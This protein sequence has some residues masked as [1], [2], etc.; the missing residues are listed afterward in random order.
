MT[1]FLMRLAA[2]R[3]ALARTPI[4]NVFGLSFL[5]LI[6]WGVLSLTRRGV[7]FL[8]EFPAIGSIS[9][10]VMRRSLEGLFLMLML[11]VAFSVLT[12]A[13]NT[14]YSSE[15]L[16]LLLSLPVEPYRVF[17]LKVAETYVTSAM[18]PALFTAPVLIGIGLE[19]GAGVG[20]YLL[21]LAAVLAL[22]A[23]PVALGAFIALVL[24]RISPSGRVKE[25]ASA[26]SVLVAAGLI[27][28]LRALRPEQLTAMNIAEFE[29][30]LQR[31]AAFEIGWMPPAW[32]SSAVLGAL[33]GR[34][35]PAAYLLAFV[36]LLLL[37]AV[38]YLAA[39]A[40]REGWV[41]SLDTGRPRL[42]PV[43]RP[44]SLWERP[45]L[46]LGRSGGIIVK[47]TRLL[48][49]DPTQWS[50]LL[51]LLALAGVYLVSTSSID[52]DLQRFKD[53]VGTMNLVFL[54]FLLAGVGIRTV[55]PVVSMEAQG[56]W[57]L[58]T[59]PIRSGQIV[60]AK[61]LHALPVM[62]VLGGGLGLLAARLLDLSPTLAYAAPIAGLLSALAVTGLGVGLGAAFPRF[63]AVSASEIPLSAGGLLYMTS[64]LAYAAAQTVLLAYPAWR[65]IRDPGQ[66]VWLEAEGVLLLG[67]ALV[68]TLAA[69]ALPLW[70]GSRR[71]ARFEPGEA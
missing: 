9:D 54:G 46:R 14:L 41:R 64:A 4:R 23:I 58:K 37:A 16:P 18:L 6:Y 25:V 66:L 50:Q 28:G 60:L 15:D 48:L 3:N 52:V 10:A 26:L 65:T 63:D 32:A 29:L 20:Y 13:V 5:G 53:A 38:A 62:I 12:S 34:V 42:D 49:R 40:Y 2:V 59:G 7:R 27:F 33:E 43:P 36:S 11:G 21:S 24:M 19:R 44:V 8:D 39:I 56:F 70:F 30:M 57:M 31:F 1:I 47:D 61:F 35:T 67:L 51:V 55:Y 22:Y 17:G 69:T 68:L 45:L 71:L